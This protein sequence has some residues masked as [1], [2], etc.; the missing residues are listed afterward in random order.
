V[1]G[2]NKHY[3]ILSNFRNIIAPDVP[4]KIGMQGKIDDV[5]WTIIG[6]IV[7]HSEDEIEDKWSEFLLFSPLYGYGWLVYESG[8]IGFSRRVRDFDLRKWEK[9]KSNKP[10][11][12]NKGHYILEEESYN[13]IIEFVQGELNWV[14]K[15][16]D[17][18]KCWDYKGVKKRALALNRAEMN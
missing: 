5:E 8:E 9:L 11:F 3:K 10:I 15:K 1:I 16:N 12:Y 18:V 17:K 7:Y 4:F 13:S 14:A 6:W 2:L